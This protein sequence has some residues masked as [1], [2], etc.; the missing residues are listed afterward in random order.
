MMNIPSL[1]NICIVGGGAIGNEYSK[2]LS[3][4]NINHQIISRSNYSKKNNIIKNNIKNIS[5]EDLSAYDGFIISVQAQNNF[6]ITKLLLEKTKCPILVEKPI[7]L[8]FTDHQILKDEFDRV[9]VALNRRKFQSAIKSKLIINEAKIVKAVVEVTEI[10][11]RIKG[12]EEVINSW[13]LANT[14]HVIDMALFISGLY[15]YDKKSQRIR[16]HSHFLRGEICTLNKSHQIYF[17]DFTPHTGNWGIDIVTNLGRLILRPLEELRFQAPDNIKRQE[18][19]LQ[20]QNFKDGF[21]NNVLDFISLNRNQFIS[22]EDY[23]YL[24]E[25]VKLFYKDDYDGKN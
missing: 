18:L 3:H 2:I 16:R 17:L 25:V 19:A 10:Q 9:H 11:N 8:N 5:A 24:M 4:L 6:E 12:S 14:I 13:A 15:D 23:D 21:L 22:F 20:P 7:A 1:K